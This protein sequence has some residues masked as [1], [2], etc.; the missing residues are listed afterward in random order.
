MA[1]DS[2]LD[3]T[4][5]RWHCYL[6]DDNSNQ[7]TL[8][9]IGEFE[10]HDQFTI[11]THNT[12]MQERQETTRYSVLINEVLPDLKDGIAATLC[13]NVTYEPELVETVLAWFEAHPDAGSAYVTQSRDMYHLDGEDAGEYM[14]WASEFGHWPIVPPNPGQAIWAPY[15]ILDH[16]QVFHRLPVEVK[17]DESHEAVKDGDARFYIELIEKRGPIVCITDEI[18]SCEHLLYERIHG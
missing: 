9:V 16:S 3:Q 2:L 8:D 13:D 6:Q 10:D 18:L 5:D 15:G 4:D 17:W 7:A 12:S 1:I 11:G 14:G